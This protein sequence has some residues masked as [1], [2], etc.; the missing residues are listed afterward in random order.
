MV[1][2][3]VEKLT[4]EGIDIT[5]NREQGNIKET[6]ERRT[7]YVDTNGL[8]PPNM[9]KNS[10]PTLKILTSDA[11]RV[12]LS[13]RREPMPFWHRNMDYDEV[14]ICISGEATWTT[15]TGEYHLKP[16]T[17]IH[18]P[19]GVSHTVVAKEGTDYTAIEIKAEARLDLNPDLRRE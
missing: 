17:M 2:K 14:I 12:E 1:D 6:I 3:I 15:E 9:L 5:F 8:L 11:T 4:S 18:I 13:K 10:G 19:R 16:G 7:S